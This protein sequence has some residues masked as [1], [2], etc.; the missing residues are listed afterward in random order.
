MT[1][2]N[3]RIVR[4]VGGSLQTTLVPG[5][6]RDQGIDQGITCHQFS[7]PRPPSSGASYEDLAAFA[8]AWQE[9]A[10]LVGTPVGSLR[11]VMLIPV[12]GYEEP[13]EE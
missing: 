9:I 8:R 10:A 2:D 5:L 7:I 13:K 4:Q 1:P 12:V 11:G 3:I 6:A